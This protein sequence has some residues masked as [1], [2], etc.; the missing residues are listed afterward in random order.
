VLA[1]RPR[2]V[3]TAARAAVRRMVEDMGGDEWV[4][5]GAGIPHNAAGDG[6]TRE[7]GVGFRAAR[8]SAQERHTGVDRTVYR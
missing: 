2:A 8:S 3:A 4:V 1:A 6:G 5:V 7:A